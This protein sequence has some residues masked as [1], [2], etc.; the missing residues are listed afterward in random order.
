M[1][2]S[3]EPRASTLGRVLRA[4]RPVVACLTLLATVPEASPAQRVPNTHL[5]IITGA[6]GE[7]RFVTQFHALAMGLR[8]VATTKFGIPD[9][10]VMYLAEQTTDRKSTRLNS[11]H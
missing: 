6:S 4:W 5:L 2:F 3:L 10:L 1:T 8:A 9:S 11:S 7:P